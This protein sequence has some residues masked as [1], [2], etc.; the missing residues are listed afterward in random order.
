MGT[1]RVESARMNTWTARAVT[2]A[3]NLFD[4]Q[5]AFYALALAVVG[6]L[7]AYTNSAE[8]PLEAGSVFT[9][10]LMWMAIAIVAFAFAASV[11]YRWLR[12]FAW[13]VYG[14]N[15]ALLVATLAVGTGVGGVSRWVTIFGLQFQFSALATLLMAVVLAN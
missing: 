9:R 5:L 11:D 13:P 3:W 15:L 4:L 14:F 12:T 2:T 1:M 8:D 10:G 7:M 6:L